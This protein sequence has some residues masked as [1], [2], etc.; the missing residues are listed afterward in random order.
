MAKPVF[1]GLD[2]GASR[3]KVAVVDAAGELIGH[4]VRKTGVDFGATAAACLDAALAMAGATR[5]NITRAVST[6]YGR[7]NVGFVTE[8]SK[9]EIGC[10]GR[11]CH[12]YFPE[13]ITIIDIGGQ[14]NKIVNLDVAGRRINF[15]MNRKCAAGTGAFLEEMAGRLDIPLEEMNDLARQSREMV[16]LGSYCTVFS[17]TEVLECIRHG[18]QVTDIVKGLFY[19]VVKRVLEMDALTERVVMTG[20]VVAHNPYIVEMA[21]EMIGRPV[22]LPE[23]PQVAGAVGAALYALEG[24]VEG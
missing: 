9:T 23:F 2:M 10:L 18:R 17:A 24:K 8:T 1:V 11:G 20:G 7:A 16:K 19:S 6:G 13:A 5:D 22:M 12:H 3:T 14:D 15:K 21:E 4:S